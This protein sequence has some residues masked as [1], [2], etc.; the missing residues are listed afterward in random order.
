MLLLFVG[1][2]MRW[3]ARLDAGVEIML[4]F[5][6][7]VLMSR[8]VVSLSRGGPIVGLL[9]AQRRQVDLVW[10]EVPHQRLSCPLPARRRG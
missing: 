1:Y 10:R 5:D 7:P 3:G 8:R 4:N 6:V 9:V 2:K